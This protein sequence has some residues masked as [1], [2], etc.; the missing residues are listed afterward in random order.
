M[1][2]A[3]LA[4]WVNE[5]E[6]VSKLLCL[7]F[8]LP[9]TCFIYIAEKWLGLGQRW[10]KIHKI[11]LNV[12]TV[13]QRFG[14]VRILKKFFKEVSYAQGCIYLIKNTE[15]KYCEILLQ[16]KIM[17]FYLNTLKNIIYFCN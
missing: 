6:Y 17:V 16:F 10:G 14:S 5:L 3:W 12:Y 2:L 1:A 4:A 15:K 9:A 13:I 8:Y 11:S 7:Y